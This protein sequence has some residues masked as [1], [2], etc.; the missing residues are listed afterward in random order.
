MEIAWGSSRARLIQRKL[1]QLAAAVDLNDVSFLPGAVARRSGD[2]VV[3]ELAEGVLM[4]LSDGSQYDT[5][6]EMSYEKLIVVEQ[7]RVSRRSTQ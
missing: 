5:V 6:Q 7:I 1:Q 4:M 3:I 2:H